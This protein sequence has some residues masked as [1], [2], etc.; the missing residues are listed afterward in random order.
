MGSIDIKET[1]KTLGLFAHIL[2]VKFYTTEDIFRWKW[3]EPEQCRGEE[4]FTNN[5]D[6]KTTKSSDI[7]YQPKS[8][9][10]VLQSIIMMMLERHELLERNMWNTN[11]VQYEMHDLKLTYLLQFFK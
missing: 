6:E 11:R 5:N 3:E 4:Q 7:K 8:M 10:V 9:L 1:L 2:P